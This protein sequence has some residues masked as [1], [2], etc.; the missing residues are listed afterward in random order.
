MVQLDQPVAQPSESR[1]LPSERYV[2]RTM[3][4]VLVT[5]DMI[6][7]YLAAILFIGNAGPTAAFGGVVSLTYL[8]IGAVTFFLP[9]VFATAQLGVLF[10]YEGS[11]YNWT[12]RALGNN[13]GFFAGV[14]YWLPNVLAIIAAA[15]GLV[16]YIQGLNNN[17]LPLPW[18]QGLVILLVI[19]FTAILGSYRLRTTQNVV[20]AGIVLTLGVVVLVGL[21]CY[22][23]LVQH[24]SATPF[25]NPGD[26]ATNG[27]NF[28][29]FGLIAL[30]YLGVSVPLNMAGEIRERAGVPRRKVITRHLFWGTILVLVGYLLCTFALL[31]VRGPAMVNDPIVPYEVVVLIESVFGKFIGAVTA[32]CIL[33]F[34]LISPLVYNYATARLLLVGS[35]DQRIPAFL[36][37]LNK[38]RVPANAVIFQS[39]VAGGICA[40]LF[41]I[42]PAIA[43][44]GKS[45]NLATGVYNVVLASMTL[46]LALSTIFYFVDLFAVYRRDQRAF[47]RQRICPM[48]ILWASM[49]VGPIACLV[50]VV[51]TLQNSWIPQLIPNS[52]WWYL[53]GSLA[54][55]SIAITA[56]GT[57]YA[58]SQAEWEDISR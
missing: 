7:I 51:D 33:I 57:M 53:V 48:W 29:L 25:N 15:D 10:P 6:A 36:G 28:P 23:F 54:F 42:V 47:H 3:S 55:A 19:A 50:V 13:W 35:I 45:A 39:V 56:I 5:F 31:V 21:A 9:C 20:N 40:I 14:S 37:R 17:W 27:Q 58:S 16:T 34:Y 41:F 18:Q 26:W 49:I 38:H 30:L 24:G 2:V 46:I 11:L 44:V 32:V 12:S 52:Q 43:S 8:L 1:A 22:I 4:P